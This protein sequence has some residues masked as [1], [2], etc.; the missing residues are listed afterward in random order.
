MDYSTSATRASDRY[1]SFPGSRDNAPE[2]SREA[3]RI[4]F[5]IAKTHRDKVLE[6]LKGEVFG[7]SSEAIAGKL[8]LSRYAVRP[9]ISELVASGEVIETQFRV[10]NDQG[11]N[12]VV[13]RAA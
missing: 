7:L 4:V 3:A 5:D 13:W 6:A 9:R 10:K 8:G 1:P 12:V 2:T 11:R